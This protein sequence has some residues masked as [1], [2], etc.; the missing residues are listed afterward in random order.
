MARKR[1]RQPAK[2]SYRY[3]PLR[4]T[5]RS[6]KEELLAVLK[7]LRA[8]LDLDI[9]DPKFAQECARSAIVSNI[10]SIETALIALDQ[11]PAP[12]RPR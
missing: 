1:T 6:N 2:E 7:R 11:P 8:L 3:E 10:I 5:P 9:I 4:G 12:K